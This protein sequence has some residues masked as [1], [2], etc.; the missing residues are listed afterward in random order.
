MNLVP[1][2]NEV[3]EVALAIY[4]E[5]VRERDPGQALRRFN[6]AK[7]ATRESFEREAKAAIATINAIRGT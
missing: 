4:T 7:P 3:R 5:F 2:Q 1:D 6:R